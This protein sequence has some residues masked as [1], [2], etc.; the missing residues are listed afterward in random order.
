MGM[1]NFV[2]NDVW[3][4]EIA[5]EMTFLAVG[6]FS[7]VLAFLSILE[8]RRRDA[9]IGGILGVV[10]PLI[11][12]AILNLHLLK[13]EAAYLVFTSFQP[14][15]WMAIGAVGIVV[16]LITSAIFTVLLML[17]KDG[18]AVKV[19][20]LI[21]SLAG[22]FVATYTG[23]VLSYERGIPFWH[24][25]AIPIIGL[26]MGAIGG[27]S[28]YSIIR[29][30]D[31]R[32]TSSLGVAMLLQ[33]AI[34][35]IH[36]HLSSIG[37]AVAKY[38]AEVALANPVFIIGMLLSVIGGLLGLSTFRLRSRYAALTVAV[39]GLLAIATLRYTLLAS[40]AWEYPLLR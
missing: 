15:S 40:G 26:L 37:P 20:G 39:L 11:A 35:S 28:A 25:A 27:L 34:F 33:A 6:S 9:L 3:G 21:A 5:I 18:V 31:V 10:F 12:L 13:P 19:V 24:S 7:I 38:S 23:L 32:I 4:V 14:R 17:G 29:P 8:G 2:L 22:I 1:S 36:I 16:L 30:G